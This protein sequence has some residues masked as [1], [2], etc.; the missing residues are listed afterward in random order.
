VKSAKS[1]EESTAEIM[2]YIEDV[3]RKDSCLVVSIKPV[4][5]KNLGS[6]KEILIDVNAE[7]SMDQ[8][9]KFLYDIENSA[10]MILEVKRFTLNSKS[11]AGTLKGT[12]LISKIIIE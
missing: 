5:A 9:S 3:S 4:G 12:F 2:T 6:Y 1:E 8:F 10:D 11:S 7:G